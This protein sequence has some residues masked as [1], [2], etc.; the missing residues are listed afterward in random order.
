MPGTVSPPTSTVKP[1]SVTSCS[2]CWVVMFT[3]VSREEMFFGKNTFKTVVMSGNV[4]SPAGRGRP[5]TVPPPGRS[6]RRS[7]VG[8][9]MVA[10]TGV[11][12]QAGKQPPPLKDPVPCPTCHSG[13]EI[14]V[15][16]LVVGVVGGLIL[17][18]WLRAGDDRGLRV[19]RRRGRR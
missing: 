11:L 18:G 12:A 14:A 7:V 3:V 2:V 15:V 10:V 9:L 6:D 4:N 8:V 17:L 5:A 19:P 13:V 16:L 1:A